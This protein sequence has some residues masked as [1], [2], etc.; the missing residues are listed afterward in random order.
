MWTIALTLLRRFWPLIAGAV[1]IFGL[2]LFVVAQLRQAHREGYKAAQI[3]Y[4]ARLVKQ[5]E[6]QFTKHQESER[7][8]QNELADLQRRSVTVLSQPVRLCVSAPSLPAADTVAG[9]A[10]ASPGDRHAVQAG[11]DIGAELVRYG[12]DCERMRRQ[13]KQAQK[14]AGL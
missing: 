13:L 1:A 3:E 12:T 14:D 9:S 4:E 2:W 10:D 7:E 8:W 6:E 11:P 5:R